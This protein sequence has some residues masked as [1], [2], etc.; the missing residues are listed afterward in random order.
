MMQAPVVI[1]ISGGSGSGKTTVAKA[2]AQRFDPHELQVV[3]LDAYYRDRKGVP[4]AERELINYDHPDA[5]DEPLLVEHILALKAGRT[6]AQPTYDYALHERAR[7]TVSVAPTPVVVIEG[8]LVLALSTVRPHLD[9]KLYVDTDA[10][11]RFL[12]RLRRDVASRGRSV[13][14]VMEQYLES[15]RPMHRSFIEPTRHHADLILPGEGRFEGAL[16][17]LEAWVKSKLGGPR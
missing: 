2:L 1:G 8:I 6:I 11:V 4:L 10:D 12:R 7:E 15:V 13:D 9:L 16:E 3:P 5:F 14:S 17:V